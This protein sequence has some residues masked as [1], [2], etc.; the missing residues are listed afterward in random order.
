M[1]IRGSDTDSGVAV[2]LRKTYLISRS[3]ANFR[4]IATKLEDVAVFVGSEASMQAAASW[5]C[6]LS[7]YGGSNNSIMKEMHF[8]KVSFERSVSK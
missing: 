8:S 1:I 3:T 2:E 5:R 7:S 6:W 4:T